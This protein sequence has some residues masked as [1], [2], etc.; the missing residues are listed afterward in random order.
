MRLNKYHVAVCVA[1]IGLCLTPAEYERARAQNADFFK[2]SPGPLSKEHAEWD[3]E[4]GCN[5]CHT[6]GKELSNEKCLGCHD[7]KNLKKRIDANEGYH[8]SAG[9]K[10][11]PCETCHIEHKGRGFDI[12]GWKVVAGGEEKFDHALTGWPLREKHAVIECKSCHKQINRAGRRTYLGEDKLCGSCHK[13]DQPHG[14]DRRA[15]LACERCH[16][17]A[18]WKPPKRQLDFDHNK[19]SDAEFP[20]EGAHKDVACGKCHPKAQFNLKQK[21]PDDC[22]NCH[23][24]SHQGH[25]FDLKTCSWCHSPNFRSLTKYEFNHAKRTRFELAGKHGTLGCYTCHTK[26]L[27]QQKPNRACEGCHGDENPH[28]NRFEAFGTP[29][30]RCGTCHPE[31]N[32]QPNKFRGSHGALTGF[33]LRGKHEQVSCRSCHRGGKPFDFERLNA[34]DKG[35]KCMSCH[36][37]QNVHNNEHT[38]IREAAARPKRPDGKPKI[39]CLECHPSEG[40]NPGDT[41]AGDTQE[42]VKTGPLEEIHGVKSTRFPL[43][44]GHKNVECGKCHPNDEFADT[45]KECGVRCHEDSL[46]EGS[47]GDECSRCHSP[48]NFDDDRFDHAEDSDWPLVG[49]HRTV[50]A[51]DDC[52]PKRKYKPTPRNCAD[53]G[54]HAKD[55]AHRG[56]LGRKCER[57]HLE[58][59]EN[60]FNH[61]EDSDYKLDGAHLTTRCGDCHPS[62]T[63]KPVPTSCFGGGACHPEPEIHKGQ[64]GT[65]C[66]SCHNTTSF[67]DV[68]PLHD[69][70]DFSLKGSHDRLP[71]ERCHI[72]NRQLRGTGNFC[73]NCHRQD[74]IHSNS[75][76]PRCGGCHTQWSFSPARF[77]HTTVG[78]N[79]TGL[80]RTLPCY[81]CH[82]TGNFGALSPSCFGCHADTGAVVGIRLQG[83]TEVDHATQTLC[84]N[85]HNPNSWV[86][87]TL[88]GRESICR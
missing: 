34:T 11:R 83:M 52:H 47:L 2:S 61:N 30:P 87:A 63:F 1:V 77:D 20:Q 17:E 84:A 71:C 16:S 46:H 21:N 67:A 3:N 27:A 22:R 59:G 24:T 43:V 62:I 6:N 18:S 69:V 76:S 13:A 74:D 49:L 14:F 58:T 42:I 50:P 45:P 7:H 32:W 4:A 78:C 36:E 12:F 60:T 33:R 38:D 86:P 55:D 88:S 73:V 26:A 39:Y 57:C 28:K 41:R 65:D 48:G 5:D 35:K 8:A 81:D 54:C 64:F 82:R 23:Q 44:R 29:V 9:V 37:H 56:N 75:I 80:H 68:K 66:E 25:L 79:L 19:K 15:M 85:C 53:V 51:C 40:V 70:G 31:S 72:D 10:G